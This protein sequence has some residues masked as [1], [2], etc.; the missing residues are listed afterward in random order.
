MTPQD[1]KL[2][3]RSRNSILQIDTFAIIFDNLIFTKGG[4]AIHFTEFGSVEDP[5]VGSPVAMMDGARLVVI[6]G[7]IPEITMHDCLQQAMDFH[8]QHE[9]KYFLTRVVP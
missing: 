9:Q 8:Q 6:H 5:V 2:L 4:N 7:G 3:A 1:R